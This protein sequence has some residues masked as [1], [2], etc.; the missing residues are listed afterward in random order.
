MNYAAIPFDASRMLQC[1][2]A[3]IIAVALSGCGTGM[4]PSGGARDDPEAHMEEPACYR[5]AKSNYEAAGTSSELQHSVAEYWSGIGRQR[6]RFRDMCARGGSHPCPATRSL[7][8]PPLFLMDRKSLATDQT[9]LPTR[10]ALPSRSRSPPSAC[11]CCGSAACN[12]PSF[13]LPRPPTGRPARRF[14]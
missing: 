3:I 4:S 13:P 9:R 10:P 1:T 5:E 14:S 11:R 6:H 2:L 8:I 12:P 7:H